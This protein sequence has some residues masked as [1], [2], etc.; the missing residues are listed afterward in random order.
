MGRHNVGSEKIDKEVAMPVFIAGRQWLAVLL[1][2]FMVVAVSACGG[3]SSSTTAMPEPEPTEPMPDPAIAQRAAISSAIMTAST[4]VNAVNNDS[5]DTEVSAAETAITDAKDAIA[6][7]TDVPAEEKA[8]NTGTVNA[9]ETQL[10]G[11]KTARQTAM[12]E[13]DKAMKAAMAKTGKELRA[14]LGETPLANITTVSLSSTLDVDAADGAGTLATG[15][16]PPE[17]ELAKGD[18]AGSLG[19]WTGTNY[20]HTNSTTKVANA[21]VVYTN[22]EAPDSKAFNDVHTVSTETTGTVPNYTAIKG[23]LT[24]DVTDDDQRGNVT[25]SAFTHSGVQNHATDS[26]TGIFTTRGYYDGAPGS[27]AAP[28]LALRPTTVK[29][30]RV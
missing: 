7:A 29:A 18:P 9:L 11:A 30:A 19:G 4:A 15:T 21:A 27:T 6:A 2:V 16:D 28:G 13:A 25:G 22:Q 23:S 3:G 10:S 14:A 17:V 20:G 24:V 12:D 26:D 5:T 8:A 1:A